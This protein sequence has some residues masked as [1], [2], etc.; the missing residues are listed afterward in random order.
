[1]NLK[2]I[3]LVLSIIAI[4]SVCNAQEIKNVITDGIR[5]C[6]STY[7]WNGQILI[8]N[9]GTETLNPLNMEGK[10]YVLSFSNGKVNS[11]IPANGCLSA[12]KGMY[13]KDDFLY[14][15]DVNKIVIYNL[16]KAD[17]CE[18]TIYFPETEMLLNGITGK[19]SWIYVSVTNTGNIYRFKTPTSTT[20]SSIVPEFYVHVPGANGLIMEGENMYIASYPPDETVRDEN[21]IYKISDMNNPSPKTLDI[22]P[23]KYD[24][25]AL[26]ADN[27]ILYASDWES[28]QILAINLLT[29]KTENI[30]IDRQVAIKGPAAISLDNDILFIPDLPSSKV[31]MVQL[32]QNDYE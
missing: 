18:Q 3:I 19:D 22:N 10:G 25:L 27:K 29:G 2:R 31:V 30:E 26:S 16:E 32:K 7:P 8:A 12:P 23:G 6:E 17:T 1:M 15:C 5:F 21:K 4:V 14:I 28:S 13:V 24:G 20:L 11:F 9:F